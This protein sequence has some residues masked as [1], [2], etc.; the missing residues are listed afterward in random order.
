MSYILAPPGASASY[1]I[2]VDKGGTGS[3]NVLDAMIT[4]TSPAF[5]DSSQT[6]DWGAIPIPPIGSEDPGEIAAVCN[7]LIT[8]L[9]SLRVIT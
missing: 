5:A 3:E 7:Q 6:P 4:L 2:A 9:Q 1:P 8:A